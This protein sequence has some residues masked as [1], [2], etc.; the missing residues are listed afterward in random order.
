MVQGPPPDPG[1]TAARWTR[2][3]PRVG[4]NRKLR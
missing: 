3:Q 1:R 2:R 4:A